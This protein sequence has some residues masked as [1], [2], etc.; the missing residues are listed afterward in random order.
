VWSWGQLS[1]R[2]AYEEH[3]DYFGLAQLGGFYQPPHK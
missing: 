2:Y 1:L 3:K